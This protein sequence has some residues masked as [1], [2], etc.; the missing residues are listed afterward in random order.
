[1]RIGLHLTLMLLGEVSGFMLGALAVFALLPA[2]FL[3][4]IGLFSVGLLG[5]GAVL[6]LLGVRWAF[7]RIGARCPRCGGRAVP[8]GRR[9]ISYHCNACGHT[10]ETRVRSNW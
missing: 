5:G 9:P 7:R 6:G 10:H 2:E 3:S 8:R 4:A 1:M